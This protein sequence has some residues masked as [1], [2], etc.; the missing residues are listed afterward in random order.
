MLLRVG[1]D[2][3]WQSEHLEIPMRPMG[4][5]QADSEQLAEDGDWWVADVDIPAEAVV[6][7]WVLCDSSRRHWDNNQMVDYHSVI[8]GSLGVQELTEVTARMHAGHS[9]GSR[10][11]RAKWR[12]LGL[13]RRPHC[14]S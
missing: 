4:R 8:R 14:S 3:W 12:G 10:L 6:V 2:A 9:W 11:Q 1:F 7:D 5:S 13:S